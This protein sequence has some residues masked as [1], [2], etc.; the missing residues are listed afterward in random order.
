MA[1]S[2]PAKT[3]ACG[4][5]LL[6]IQRV[7]PEVRRIDVLTGLDD[8]AADGARAGEE[9]EKLALSSQD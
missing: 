4:D 2:N 7:T 6:L 9:F 1:G 8:G 5:L 3:V